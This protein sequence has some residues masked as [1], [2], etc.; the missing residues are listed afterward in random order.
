MANIFVPAL[1][2]LLVALLLWAGVEDVRR[3]EIANWKNAVIALLAPLWWVA[4]GLPLWPAMAI[5][6]ALGVVVLLLFGLAFALGQMGGGDVKLLAALALWLPLRPLI[7]MLVLMALIG[8]VLTLTMMAGRYLR[9][10]EGPLEVPYGVAIV[11]ACLITL[12]EPILNQF[13]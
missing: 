13:S 1:L 8:G 3:R 12:R 11:L 6:F 7:S 4:L 2:A 10:S 9:R 5:Q